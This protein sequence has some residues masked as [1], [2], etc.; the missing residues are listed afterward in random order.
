MSIMPG[1]QN[2]LQLFL[3]YDLSYVI[4]LQRIAQSYE[5]HRTLHHNCMSNVVR[6]SK[7]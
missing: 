1:R 7:I 6:V 5:L 4:L 2:T 3:I